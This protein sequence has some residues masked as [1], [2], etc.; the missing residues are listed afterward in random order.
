LVT[1]GL[2]G[3]KEPILGPNF[4][5]TFV[6]AQPPDISPLLVNV[7]S[8]TLYPSSLKVLISSA[9]FEIPSIF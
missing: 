9:P 6:P 8:P 1:N 7:F 4:A 5:P 3:I 2:A